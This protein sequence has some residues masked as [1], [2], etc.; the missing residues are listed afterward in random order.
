MRNAAIEI[1]ARRLQFEIWHRREL[2]FPLGVPPLSVMFD[3]AIAAHVL[4]LEYESRDCILSA[5]GCPLME[6]AGTL[7]R[8]RGII[9]VSRRFSERVQR[10][11][12]AHEI[13]HFLLHPHFGARV[14]HRDLPIDG[15]SRG[16]PR[17][18]KEADYFGACLLAPKKAVL[19]QFKARFGFV[20]PLRLDENIAFHL[21]G[22]QA[23]ELFVPTNQLLN[24]A[25]AVAGTE[26][27]AGRFF[28]SMA[29]QFGLSVKAM[30][31]RL[32]ELDLVRL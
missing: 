19:E 28:R 27:F 11:T 1:E 2:L 25:A 31:I 18:D 7:D 5:D 22:S 17:E 4:D 9:S 8:G 16:R 14:V 13:G 29:D 6:A 23:H 15:A 32:T 3:P 12:G 26:R 21:R 10:F 30:A 24:F 20:G